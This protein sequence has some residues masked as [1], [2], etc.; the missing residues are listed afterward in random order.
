MP[1][2]LVVTSL[3]LVVG[4]SSIPVA[5][6]WGTAAQSH[7]ASSASCPTTASIPA[8]RNATGLV[9]ADNGFGLRLFTSIFVQNADK[10]VFISPTSA[11]I[12]LDMVYAGAR[13]ISQSQMASTLGLANLSRAAVMTRAS[14]LL[15]G[16]R[17]T[18]AKVQLE[19]ANSVWSR[20]GVQFQQAFLTNAGHYFGAKVGSLD[21]SSAGAPGT[22]NSWVAC[23]THNT[24][25]SIVKNIAADIVMYVLNATYFHG[26]WKTS[27]DSKNTHAGIFTTGS[28]Q[29]VQVPFMHLTGVTFPYYQSPDFQA[30]SLPYGRG[31]FS[32]VIVLP[33]QGLSLPTFAHRLTLANWNSWVSQ[34]QPASI[35]LA[36][37]KFTTRNSWSLNGPLASLGMRQA[38]GPNGNFSGICARCKLSQV[39]QKSYLSIDEKG[40]TAAAVT[41]GGVSATAVHQTMLVDHPFL[42]AIRDSK[43]GAILFLGAENNPA[44]LVP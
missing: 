41:S 28:G 30:M 4:A 43:T 18:D 17:S 5:H 21:F 16:L 32:M 20:A 6:A 40:T 9:S 1:R 2:L 33:R 3:L 23:A 13:G 10:D 25:T 7:V 35:P 24:I 44:S 22:I 36:L 37:P 42:I 39:R 19:I 26:E 34:L 29:Q 12:A 27:F 11:A 31:R 8:Q 15:A 38:I 14:A